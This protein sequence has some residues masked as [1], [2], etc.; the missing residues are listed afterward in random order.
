MKTEVIKNKT[1]PAKKDPVTIETV[2]VAYGALNS[3]T[4]D[5]L[6]FKDKSTILK[7]LRVIKRVG[8][9]YDDFVKDLGEK[10]KPKDWSEVEEKRS[11]FAALSPAEKIEINKTVMKYNEEVET[12]TRD[13]LDRVADELTDYTHITASVFEQ[14]VESNPK[15]TAGQILALQ[16]VLC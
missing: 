9:D 12:A 8:R 13:E 7:A 10:L 5:K 2:I 6:E 11:R 3:A 1:I 14:L 4:L 16:D 15:L